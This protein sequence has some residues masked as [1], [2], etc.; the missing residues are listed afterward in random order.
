MSISIYHN[1]EY[2]DDEGGSG[3][4]DFNYKLKY[5]DNS[6]IEKYLLKNDIDID[7][8][9]IISIDLTSTRITKIGI[10]DIES[11]ESIDL[12]RTITVI[13]E[14]YLAGCPNIESVEIG[15][16]KLSHTKIGDSFCEGCTNLHTLVLPDCI[17]SIGA[18]FC[19][20]SK[21]ESF[22]ARNIKYIGDNFLENCVELQDITFNCIKKIGERFLENIKNK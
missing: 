21:L 19:T 15:D 5:V 1:P 3:Y 13:E 2:D 11:L 14:G 9:S 7:I 8:D 10:S 17:D 16:L 20:S 6:T 12:P 18:N 4:K 22:D